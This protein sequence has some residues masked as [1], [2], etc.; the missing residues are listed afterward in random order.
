[1]AF[2]PLDEAE[3]VVF[4]KLAHGQLVLQPSFHQAELRSEDFPRFSATRWRFE[5]VKVL[6]HLA[7]QPCCASGH[8]GH[9]VRLIRTVPERPRQALNVRLG[10]G[11]LI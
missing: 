8:L 5:P 10:L 9:S 1:M 6:L 3:P 7:G 2:E 11:D 4:H